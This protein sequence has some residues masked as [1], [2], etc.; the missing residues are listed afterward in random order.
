MLTLCWVITKSVHAIKARDQSSQLETFWDNRGQQTYRVNPLFSELCACSELRKQWKFTRYVCCRLALES[1][2]LVYLNIM[3]QLKNLWKFERDRLSDLRD[4]YERKK[5][6]CHTKL[7]AFRCLISRPHVLNLRS[8]NQ[9][10][11]NLLLSPKL[12]HFRGSR[13][14]H[15]FI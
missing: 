9:I 10:R 3:H 1:L 14:S 8:R 13:F 4:N 2:L 11:G 12:R 6:P 7:C 5:H 15:C